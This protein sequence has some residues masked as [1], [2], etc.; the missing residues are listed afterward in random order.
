MILIPIAR[1]GR[2]W[3]RPA[4]VAVALTLAAGCGGSSSPT[5]D[6]DTIGVVAST[7]IYGDITRGVGGDAVDVTVILDDPAVDPHEFQ[8]SARDVLA[9][10]HA[11]VV[12]VNG[13]GY[14]AF[15]DQLLEGADND[16]AR[17]I[18]V[19]ELVGIP[20]GGNEHVFYD[21][22]DMRNLATELA[23]ALRAAAPGHED[24]IAAASAS[25]DRELAGLADQ[26]AAIAADF[27]ATPVVA[28]DPAAAAFVTAA[29]L[30]N[31]TPE[32]FM[33]AVEDGTGV[34][35]RTARAV[36]ELVDGA[37]VRA[38]VTEPGAADPQV[39]EVVDA[40]RARDLPVVEVTEMLP[41][42]DT[43][44]GWMR[45]NFDGLQTALGGGS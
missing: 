24:T 34:A 9:L 43:Y 44:V 26:V 4:L 29:H 20:E 25:F 16:S 45:T 42:G 10:S 37:D 19:A 30:D 32:A 31:R 23:T 5:V 12:I 33:I 27:D 21:P 14:D 15:M 11:D 41:P 3:F 22:D 36:R 17:V 2:R 38:V 28:T 18:D 7:A 8:G 40:A 39:V 35:P 6:A 1:S 13:G